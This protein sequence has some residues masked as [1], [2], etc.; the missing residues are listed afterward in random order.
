MKHQHIFSQPKKVA[1]LQYVP[2]GGGKI[3]YASKCKC[4]KTKIFTRWMITKFITP[5]SR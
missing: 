1:S 5:A 2:S 3:A 4:G